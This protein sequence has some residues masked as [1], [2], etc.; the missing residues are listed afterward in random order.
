[1]A[2]GRPKGS[3]N[4]IGAALKDS[5]WHAF[6]SRGGAKRL[7][8]WAN[9]CN[10]NETEFYRMCAKIIPQES[11]NTMDVTRRDVGELTNEQ[12]LE[13]AGAAI[14]ARLAPHADTKET[15]QGTVQ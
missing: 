3:P 11:H 13:I 7:V 6:A 14:E 12:L 10:A 9:K 2:M 5:F 15:P 4:R 1:M 8:Q